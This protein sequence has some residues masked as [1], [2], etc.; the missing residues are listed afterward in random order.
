MTVAVLNAL[1][2]PLLADALPDWIEPRWFASTDELLEL[3]PGA[4]IGWFDT[5][6]MP[7]RVEAVS[8]AGMS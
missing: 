3:A 4:E 1:L 7:A 5:Y 6:D 2:R 8:R